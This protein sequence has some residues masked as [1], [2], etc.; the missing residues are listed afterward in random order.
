MRFKARKAPTRAWT[1][2]QLQAAI[3][4]TGNYKGRKTRTGAPAGLFLRTWL[5]LG[6]ESGARMSDN[7][8][9]RGEHI[10]GDV[11]RWTQAK[12]GDAICKVLSPECLAA[13]R[14]MLELSADGTVLGWVCSK[15]QALQRM[16]AHLKSC[17]LDGTSK[18]LRRSGATHIEMAEP[19]KASLHLG[20]RTQGLAASAYLDWGQI[21]KTTPVVP[22]LALN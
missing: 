9:F 12:T 15:R 19:G 10:D 8:S 21:R 5:L 17:G 3:N 13:V 11:L 1:V 18:W 6:Y 16:K 14:Q 20:H 4:A 2:E 22:R 7:F